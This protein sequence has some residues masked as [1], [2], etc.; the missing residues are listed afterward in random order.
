MA[1]GEQAEAVQEESVSVELRRKAEERRDEI[2][3]FASRIKEAKT[4]EERRVLIEQFRVKMMPSTGQS[5]AARKTERS[6]SG[7]LEELKQKFA[8]NPELKKRLAA[9]EARLT[10]I[11]GLKEA[12]EAVSKADPKDRARLMEEVSKRRSELMKTQEAAFAEA[13]TVSTEAQAREVPPQMAAMR[14]KSEQRK[15]EIE[16]FKEALMKASPEERTKLLEEWRARRQE[17]MNR[18]LAEVPR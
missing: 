12:M 18:Q 13:R 3:A 14:E 5:A 16:A 15:R 1:D 8:A 17:E 6:S 10:A 9:V 4:P 7:S 11:Q 2:L